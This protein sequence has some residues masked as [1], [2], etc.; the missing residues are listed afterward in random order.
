LKLFVRVLEL[1]RYTLK[2]GSRE[3]LVELFDREFV[4]SQEVLGMRILGTFRDLDDPDQFVWLRGFEDVAAR[5]PA[6]QTFYSGPVWREHS[7]AAN[8]KAAVGRSQPLPP[9]RQSKRLGT[10]EV[11]E[12]TQ[13]LSLTRVTA[14]WASVR[15][16]HPNAPGSLGW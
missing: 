14:V 9:F 16:C 5:A 12:R 4:E 3:T 6:L 13:K 7:A 8:A 15:E 2:P 10:V 1:R 11:E